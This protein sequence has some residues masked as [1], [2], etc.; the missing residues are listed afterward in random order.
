MRRDG[1]GFTMIE[2]VVT[3]A[4]FGTFLM[5]L[6]TLSLEMRKMEKRYPVNFMTHPQ[7]VAV[8]ARLRRDVVDAFGANPYPSASPDGKYQQ[9]D[10]TL[11]IQTMVGGGT[12]TVVWDFS[13]ATQVHRISYNVGKATHWMARG[14]PS[15]FNAT[16]D[17]IDEPGRPFGVR[18]TAVDAQGRLAI[19]QYLLPRAHD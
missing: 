7:V 9:S 5:I 11:I 4:I 17:A 12:Q 13:H 3:L 16:I 1:R 19:D 14:L 10:K 8:F 6:T 18:V 15:D 2:I